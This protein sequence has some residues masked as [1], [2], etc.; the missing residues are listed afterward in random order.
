MN[1]KMII[2]VTSAIAL[3]GALLVGSLVILMN[4]TNPVAGYGA[5]LQG[6]F[7]S[8]KAFAGTLSS[9]TP[10][11]FTGLGV[12]VS[13]R[14]GMANIGA[15]GQLYMGAIASAIVAAYAPIPGV[16]LPV[17][18]L[19]TAFLISGLYGLLP[20][21]LKVRT[22]TN[23]VVTTL[24]LNYVAQLFTSYLANY[25]LKKKGSPL[26]MTND[27][28]KNARLFKLVKGTRFN[29]GFLLAVVICILI[30]ILFR[31]TTAG[32]EMRVSGQNAL[33]AR[34]M[35]IQVDRRMEQGMFL[36]G[37]LCGIGGAILVLGIQYNFVQNISPGYG[38][39]GL[40]I[41]LMAANN[42][43]AVIPVSVLFG[44]LRYGSVKMELLTQIPAELSN[45]IQAVVILFMAARV[46]M[47][48]RFS[49]YLDGAALKKRNRLAANGKESADR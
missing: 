33:F 30:A 39:D 29:V 24:M 43:I 25:P 46:A 21:V 40:T 38:F 34:Y 12:A 22:N 47:Q 23:E 45:V 44:A 27:I 48:G 3:I 37:G 1:K 7:G 4:G 42:S 32:F 19:L 9:A 35:G 20:A 11:I 26:G 49:D 31:Y 16:L 28:Q 41:A 6:S 10:L 2:P 14:A 36:G 18:S 15:E 13:F 8:P 17:F 5:L